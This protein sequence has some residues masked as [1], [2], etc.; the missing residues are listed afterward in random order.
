MF[1]QDGEDGCE[2]VG[3]VAVFG[4]QFV[5]ILAAMLFQQEGVGELFVHERLY[6]VFS[7]FFSPSL[8]IVCY[9]DLDVIAGAF[10]GHNCVRNILTWFYANLPNRDFKCCDVPK[11]TRRPCFMMPILVH[12]ASHSYLYQEVL[13]F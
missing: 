5:V 13:A 10:M 4:G 11:Q 9:L 2:L 12:K 7:L 3:V 6:R 1:L 8:V